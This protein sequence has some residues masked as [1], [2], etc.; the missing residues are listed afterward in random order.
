[1]AY[2]RRLIYKLRNFLRPDRA[3]Q[4]LARE[5]GS[6]LELLQDGFQQQGMDAEAARLAAKRAYGGVEQAKELHREARSWLWLEQ[7]RQDIRISVR[8]LLKS[9]GFSITAVLTLALGIGANTAIFSLINSVMLKTL[10][11]SHPDQLLQVNMGSKDL[12][13]IKGPF[14][15]NPIWE[16]LRDR[17]DVFS[18]IF[19]YAVGRFNL[20]ARGE[21]R[22][23]QGNYPQVSFS[24]HWDCAPYS[25]EPSRG[26]TISGVALGLPYSVMVSGK[27]STEGAPTWWARPS[28]S[29]II[30]SKF[31][32]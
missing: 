14:F 27:A 3:E 28:H 15:S 13:G 4:D 2:Y 6:H 16:H 10:P 8:A 21:A 1:M 32:A 5:I 11:V 23:V 7:L 24:T 26:L 18:G 29:I 22:Y 12:W 30:F 9:F 19:A 25:V 17:Q 31:W 20:A